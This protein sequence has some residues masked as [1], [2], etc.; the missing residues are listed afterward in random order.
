VDADQARYNKAI[1]KKNRRAN[2]RET[3]RRTV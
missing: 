2:I 3:N 1:D